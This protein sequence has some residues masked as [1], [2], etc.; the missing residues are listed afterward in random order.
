VDDPVGEFLRDLDAVRDAPANTL[1]AYRRDLRQFVAFLGKDATGT[2]PAEALRAVTPR[3]VRAFL[4]SLHGR[5]KPVTSARK[6]SAIRGFYAWWRDRGAVA[7]NPATAVTAPRA[8]RGLPD[9][10]TVDEVFGV[11]EGPARAG[12]GGLRDHAILELLYGGGVR[13]SELV[14]LDV[15]ALDLEGRWVRVVG[16]GRKE[17]T[18]PLGEPAVEALRAWL[19]CRDGLLAQRRRTTDALFLNARGGRLTRRSVAR[20]LDRWALATGLG[21]PTHPHALRHSYATHLLAGGADLRSI[22]ELL[23]H[24]T[25]ATTQTYTH[26]DLE[27]LMSVYDAAHPRA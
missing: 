19:P 3:H 15:G 10:L 12:T 5:V 4:A 1:D 23:G 26:V 6:L 20:L 21:R 8:R 27:H 24:A 16:K 22:Q 2:P 25:L 18:V 17:R 14:T 9:F 11:V 13:V 7:D